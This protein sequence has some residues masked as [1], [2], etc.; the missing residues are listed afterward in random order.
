MSHSSCTHLFLLP[1][2][3]VTSAYRIPVRQF[4]NSVITLQYELSSLS[5]NKTTIECKK[6]LLKCWVNRIALHVSA[7]WKPSSKAPVKKG[8][9]LCDVFIYSSE[10]VAT[11]YGLDS[12]GI[13]VRFPVGAKMSLFSIASRRALGPTWSGIG[14]C[15]WFC[16]RSKKSG[17]WNL[18]FTPI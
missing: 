14:R 6:R 18:S 13:W 12:Q 10:G 3:P 4:T 16:F 8:D 15:R 17:A 7:L 11:S 9:C 5:K 1:R 2:S